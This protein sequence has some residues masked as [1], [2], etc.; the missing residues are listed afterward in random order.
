MFSVVE[1]INESGC[2]LLVGT[3]PAV[4]FIYK[5]SALSDA[6]LFYLGYILKVAERFRLLLKYI[7]EFLIVESPKTI[8]YCIVFLITTMTG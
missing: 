5:L 8:Y 6:T 1:L 2:W 4:V 7:L 3:L